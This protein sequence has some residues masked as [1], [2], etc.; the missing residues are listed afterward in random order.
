MYTRGGVWVFSTQVVRLQAQLTELAQDSADAR[1]RSELSAADATVRMS[2]ERGGCSVT[3]V[4]TWHYSALGVNVRHSRSSWLPPNEL[5]LNC[6]RLSHDPRRRQVWR[7]SERGV[8]CRYSN[9]VVVQAAMKSTAD[10]AVRRVQNEAAF[11]K[12]QLDSEVGEAMECGVLFVR[13]AL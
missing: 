6:V 9:M 10:A 7:C 2:G 13:R 5:S 4:I 8:L 3:L 12:S 11:L 1:Q